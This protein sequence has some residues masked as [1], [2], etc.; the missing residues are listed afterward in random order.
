MKS[1]RSCR[2]HP[3]LP[4]YRCHHHQGFAHR[5][6]HCFR[7]HGF[8]SKY[9]ASTYLPCV[10]FLIWGSHGLLALE[11]S[12][13][14]HQQQICVIGAGPAGLAALKLIKDSPQ[15]KNGSWAAT[16]FEARNDVGGVW[17]GCASCQRSSTRA[18]PVCQMFTGYPR[19][20]WTIHP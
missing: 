13:R 3:S 12:W 14:N 20:R 2:H 18:H 17:L 1:F 5:S 6:R 9:I 16:A 15:F 19:R 4:L 7:R 10:S 8:S 11:A